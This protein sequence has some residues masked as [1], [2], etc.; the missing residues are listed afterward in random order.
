M[1]H[2]NE[3][4][5]IIDNRIDNAIKSNSDTL[6]LTDCNVHVLPTVVLKLRNSLEILCLTNNK[7]IQFPEWLEKFE[8]LRELYLED[9]E[10]SFPI[11]LSNECE[12][13]TNLSYLS[14]NNNPITILTE[15][16]FQLKNL[17][18]LHL[19]KCSLNEIPNLFDSFNQLEKLILSENQLKSLPDS[20]CQ[21]SSIKWLDISMNQFVSIPNVNKL[22]QLSYFDVSNNYIEE[23]LDI[24]LPNSLNRIL[25]SNNPIV[26]L[27]DDF[28]L[29]TTQLDLID[30]QNTKV[31]IDDQTKIRTLSHILFSK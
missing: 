31:S 11:Q 17:T 5:F 30:L 2:I 1:N 15:S 27:T 10:I 29:N 20:L 16:F 7:I 18:F 21:C 13:S 28:I 9:N 12:L 3:Q 14:L 24:Q 23:L 4:N 26:T 6:N 8:Q 25:L 19:R 22:C